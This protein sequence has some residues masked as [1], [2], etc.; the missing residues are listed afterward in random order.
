MPLVLLLAGF[1]ACARPPSVPS[2][3]LHEKA[4]VAAPV[5]SASTCAERSLPADLGQ[6]GVVRMPSAV[7]ERALSPVLA[8]LCGCARSSVR[9]VVT[10]TPNL[11]EVTARAPQDAATDACLV[12]TL[13]HA[14]FEA[15]DMGEGSDCIDC[16]P[17]PIER[18]K[19]AVIP[20]WL[21][22]APLPRRPRGPS[23]TRPMDYPL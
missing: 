14:R 16:G 4:A 5:L 21:T 3:P 1:T 8:A 19:G 20:A 12:T 6:H 7:W 17:R 22:P 9:V 11:G 10:V 13:G 15:F 2:T 18:P 23:F